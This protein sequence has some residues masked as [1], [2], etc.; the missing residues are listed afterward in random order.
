MQK[1]I[2][3]IL[4]LVYQTATSQSN[5]VVQYTSI[6][7]EIPFC[8][9]QIGSN[10]FIAI[11]TCD[12]HFGYKQ[13]ST[14]FKINNKGVIVGEYSTEVSDS[15]YYNITN[16]VAINESEFVTIA[17]CK[18]QKLP[19]AQIGVIKFDTS[20]QVIWEKK[21]TLNRASV[22]NQYATINSIGNIVI[23]VDVTN[24]PLWNYALSFTEMTSDGDSVK[25][26]YLTNGNPYLTSIFSL[27]EID[28]QYKAFVK[29]YSSY[30]PNMGFSEILQLDTDFNIVGITASPY[31]IQEY[32]TAEK[33]DDSRYYLAGKAY[34]SPTHFDVGIAKLSISE[35]SIAFNHAG[36]PGTAVDYSGWMKCLSVANVNSIYTGGTGYDN[37]NFY[38]CYTTNKV[39]ML[40]NY[41]SLLNCRWTRFY[42]SDTAC[43][44]MST[45]EATSDGGC[46]MGGMFYTPSRP[47]NL[48]DA[49]IIKVDSLG[50]FTDIPDFALVQIHEAIVYPNPGFDV[51]NIQSGPQ[52]TGAEFSMFDASGNQVLKTALISTLEQMDISKFASGTYFWYIRFKGKI[53][54]QGKWI[55]Q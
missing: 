25:S 3:I 9:S 23:G 49:V 32:M 20:L 10:Q 16:I 36:K 27:M 14:V 55:K 39:L 11:R 53:V 34:S 52:I 5:Y 31:W 46:I 30:V 12:V 21:F 35:D 48:L 47:E 44:T 37:G 13:N 18:S 24:Y 54:D 19:F 26:G 42:G 38:N 22:D 45:L 29:G 2:Q 43:Y 1:F 28:G 51:V 6:Q 50:L 33:I 17:R 40:S 7:E 8:I 41:D 4:L 15:S